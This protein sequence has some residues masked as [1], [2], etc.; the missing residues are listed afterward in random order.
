MRISEIA[1]NVD[2]VYS[3]LVLIYVEHKSTPSTPIAT[4]YHNQPVRN[5]DR[6]QPGLA[7]KR[8]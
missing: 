5:R 4:S 3:K 1:A 7:E 2:A 8:A 6:I